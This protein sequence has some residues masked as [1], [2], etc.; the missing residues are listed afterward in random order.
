MRV[1]LSMACLLAALPMSAEEARL[2]VR[3]SWGHESGQVS[4]RHVRLQAADGVKLDAVSGWSL[5]SGDT[6]RDNT[7]RARS[8]KGD[9]DGLD[10]TL[11]YD[12]TP[13]RRIENVHILWS[14]LIAAA[15]ADTTLRL[16]N[17]PALLAHPRKLT[18]FTNA[19]GTRG[20]SVAVE[21]LLEQK[22]MWIPSLDMFVSAGDSPAAYELEKQRLSSRKGTRILDKVAAEP[23]ATYEQY[24]ALWP[25]MGDPLWVYPEERGPG[26]IIGL[27]W[28]SS[29]AKFGVDRGAG[30]WNDYGNRDRFRL[31]Y[32]FA[33]I[34]QGLVPHWKG[35]RLRDGLPVVTTTLE[36]DGV[37][38]EVE[39]Y[40]FPL[41]GIP[42]ERRGDIPMVMMQ[43]VRLTDMTGSARVLP[44]TVVHRRQFAPYVNTRLQ[45]EQTGT[46]FVL[47]EE[48][49]GRALLAIE[50]VPNVRIV[51][52]QDYQRE[53]K[54][55]D[56]Y[57]LIDLPANG[58]REFVVKLPS[59][60]V[61]ANE[62]ATLLALSYDASLKATVQFWSDYVARGARFEVPEKVVNDLY[63]ANLWHAL[64]L[65]RRHGG[66]GSSIDLPY[67]NFAYS[68]TGTP[69]PI[70]QAVYVDYMLHDLRG[71]H[72]ISN[73]ELLVQFRNNQEANGHINGY[74]NWVV[75]T[76][77]MIYVT[78]KNY[79]LS[80]DRAG[81][82]RLLPY[83][84]KAMDWCIAQT[85]EQP[86][87]PAVARGLAF[88]PLNDLTGE[89]WWSF[90]QAYI[91]AGLD[92]FA[93][94]LQAFGHPRAGES[95]AAAEKIRKSI[96]HAFGAASAMST[97]VQL[98][99]GTWIP[100]VPAEANTPRRLFEQWYATDIDTGSVHLLRLKALDPKGD[101][102][103]ALLHDH[104]DNLFYKGLG[105][106]N[107]PVYNQHSTAYLWRDM[108]KAIIRSFY[109]Y[110]A[111]GFS[112]STL[113]PVEHRWTHGQ[114]FGPP[115]TDGAW[116]ELYRNMILQERE[117][118]IL[119]IGMATPRAWLADA[120]GIVVERAPTE[121]G[122][123]NV[124][125]Q[126]NATG[127]RAQ[128][129]ITDRTPPK[130]LLVRLRHPKEARMQSV[131]VNGAAWT[132]F[133]ANQEWIRIPAPRSGRYTIEARY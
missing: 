8:G 55:S 75:Y 85:R 87:A 7:V 32:G 88:G 127:L 39:Q 97:L 27:A 123:V 129:D 10:L 3:I 110:M 77:S 122:L 70:N 46:S 92:K 50:N 119:A 56:L 18:V 90:N 64:R 116:F 43:K 62:V 131:Q 82:D 83:A 130:T 23:E 21:Q 105:I 28:D 22:T 37:R 106:A 73:E 24:K 78:A 101:L 49:F 4:D 13:S 14:D 98:R 93:S 132:D 117:E 1:L 41:H 115:S 118:G 89:G 84:L 128:I 15:D 11:V 125:I 26:H 52:T 68:Q 30:V 72:A 80:G 69:W 63:R 111:S 31:W 9:V 47:R 124:T 45:L 53:Q 33:D 38:Y 35:Q 76:P 79:L 71:Y 103:D 120:R 126:P 109:S 44:V 102:A 54:R 51:G 100:Y 91:Y 16:L 81:F 29:L 2:K 57:A 36:R 61:D 112:H 58:T 19:E 6:L 113:E 99:D 34:A 133:D 66:E 48:G 121:F 59:P 104:E 40:A 20:F 12:S 86:G 74:A 95:R 17:D 25:D 107:E 67:S 65:P 96:D 5:E 108:P 60:M 94:A 42:K 114:Y